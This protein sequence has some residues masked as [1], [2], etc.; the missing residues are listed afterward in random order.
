M[1]TTPAVAQG[2]PSRA[3][4]RRCWA[5]VGPVNGRH[6]LHQ[7]LG[8]GRGEQGLFPGGEA[9][10]HP[11]VAQGQV[12][13][14][15]KDLGLLCL[16]AFEELAAHRGVEK[17]IG[18]GDLGAPGRGRHL[19][20]GD[21]P[22][23]GHQAPAAGGPGGAGDK[24]Q[25][26]HRGNAGEGLAP[27]AQGGDVQEIFFPADFAGGVAQERQGGILGGHA[28]AVVHHPDTAAAPLLD[29]HGDVA[30]LGVQGI[31]HQFLHH[32]GRPRDHLARGNA[33]GRLTVQDLYAPHLIPCPDA[34]LGL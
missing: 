10:L 24:L 3:K 17:K 26:A 12:A 21:L 22:A 34:C 18:D 1:E 29:F 2:A 19:G 4:G 30:G 28:G 16:P 27:E 33:G 11:G 32:R 31:F 8:G 5:G 6:P 20:E 14:G 7:G 15:L 9:E 13:H 23:L 25:A